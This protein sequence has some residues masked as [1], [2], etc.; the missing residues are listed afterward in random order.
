MGDQENQPVPSKYD[1]V[2]YLGE[3]TESRLDSML[4]YPEENCR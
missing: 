4:K 1:Q 3:N 2:D